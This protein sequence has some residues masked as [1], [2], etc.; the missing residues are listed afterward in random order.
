MKKS[1]FSLALLLLLIFFLPTIVST[2]YGKQ[3]VI[4]LLAKASHGK[5]SIKTLR[6]RWLGPQKIENLQI[7]SP[8]LH[9][10]I[11]EIETSLKLWNFLA[12]QKAD[13]SFLLHK[14]VHFD[15]KNGNLLV[16]L[17]KASIEN[18]RGNIDTTADGLKVS[19]SAK[20]KEGGSLKAEGVIGAA[21][22]SMTWENL[23]CNLFLRLHDFP[24]L[25]F[26]PKGLLPL[27]GDQI[28]MSATMKIEK[29]FG[30]LYVIYTS[31]TTKTLIDAYLNKGL[32][33]LQSP[34]TLSL[35]LTHKLSRYLLK[36]I[37]PFFF[38][39]I[40]ADHPILLDIPK[41]GF[42][43]PLGQ[44]ENFEMENAKIDMGKVQCLNGGILA[45]AVALLKNPRLISVKEMQVWFTPFSFSIKGGLLTSKRL[46]ML[47]ADSLHIATWGKI[48]LQENQLHMTLGI[49]KET[50]QHAFNLKGLPP[51]YLLQIPIKGKPNHPKID[52]A[53]AAAR[54]ATLL[55]LPTS[56]QH[57]KKAPNPITPFPWEK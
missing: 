7:T 54:I 6:L 21:I 22:P 14:E 8:T 9:L 53:E 47:I 16:P 4:E 28:D 52:G 1:L 46:D 50:L 10:S 43:L 51:N 27:L 13:L 55:A 57:E 35:H 29:G 24:A 5:V 37:N 41:E 18:I 31:S 40:S 17:E 20:N 26:F 32:L 38:L 34:I 45:L 19:L 30:S 48:N 49:T 12:L 15:I 44:L 42:N 33:T 3:L 11:D 56:A 25:P 23:T 2:T 36:D 39:A